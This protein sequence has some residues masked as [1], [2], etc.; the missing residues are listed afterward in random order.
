MYDLISLLVLVGIFG[1]GYAVYRYQQKN[2][3]SWTDK[4]RERFNIIAILI[5]TAL[6]LG[7]LGFD[8]VVS[9]AAVK[10]SHLDLQKANRD[11]WESMKKLPLG[12]EVTTLGLQELRRDLESHPDDL[13]AALG[14]AEFQ[15]LKDRLT[16]EEQRIA[17][18]IELKKK[19]ETAKAELDRIGT[20]LKDVQDYAAKFAELKPAADAAEAKR[21]IAP[22]GNFQLTVTV[23]HKQQP[24]FD[25]LTIGIVRTRLECFDSESYAE[26]GDLDVYMFKKV[27]KPYAEEVQ[28]RLQKLGATVLISE[29]A[30]PNAR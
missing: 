7:K 26:S 25:S 28:Q 24:E 11:L 16:L 27:S 3:A 13:R 17:K 23:K 22:P 9:N 6:I 29:L 20:E 12:M 8:V 4:G 18:Y 15:A 19:L 1:A 14:D 5:F 2:S 10:Q 21:R 30:P